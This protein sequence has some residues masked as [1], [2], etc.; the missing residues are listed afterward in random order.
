MLLPTLERLMEPP[1]GLHRETHTLH[2]FLIHLVLVATMAERVTKCCGIRTR[3]ASVCAP[4]SSSHHEY[5]AHSRAECAETCRLCARC[6]FCLATLQH[7]SV[8]GGHIRKLVVTW[9]TNLHVHGIVYNHLSVLVEWIECWHAAATIQNRKGKI[10][11]TS[12]HGPK[13]GLK[14]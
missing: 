14:K 10:G 1:Q 9:S 5:D 4:H 12:E 3:P 11:Y 8:T 2:L 7:Q 6:M 13:G